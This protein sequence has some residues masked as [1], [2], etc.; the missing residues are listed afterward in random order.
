MRT[1]SGALLLTATTTCALVTPTNAARPAAGSVTSERLKVPS[2]PS[3]VR[4]LA[5]EP[6]VDPFL[7]QL[8][9]Q[10]PIELPGGFGGLAPAVALVY[11]GA[12]GNGPLGIGW[13]LAETTISR[14]T[15]LGVPRFDDTDVLEISG[16]AS[17]RLVAIGNGE[18]RVEGM[19]QTVRVREVGGGFEVDDGS[20]VRYRLGVTTAGRRE[21]DATSTLAW[22]VE[23]Q[24]NLMGERIRYEYVKDRG[25]LYPSRIVWGPS[26]VYSATFTYEA[27]NDATTSYRE[28]FR[29][30]TRK[31]LAAIQVIA[32]GVEQRAYQLAYD[33]TFPVARLAGVTA[34][35]RAG[36]GAW[37]ALTFTYG[38]NATPAITPITGIGNWRLNSG[39]TT[40]VDLDGDGAAEL[41]QLASGSHSYLTNQNGSF[42]GLQPLTGNAQAIAA[43]QLQDVDGDG[44]VELLQD[45]GNGWAVYKFTKTQWVSQA[46]SLPNGVWP[47]SVG[48]QLKQPQTTRFADLNG[49]GAVDAIQWDND[50]LKIRIATRTGIRAPYNVPKIAGGVVPSTQ[51]RFLDVNGDGLDDYVVT[52][53]SRLDVY[54]GHGDGTFEPALPIAYPFAGAISNPED[55][56]LADLDRD[57]LVDLM[58]LDLGTVRWFR[59]K[60]DGTFVATPVTL[61][62]PETLTSAVVVTVADINGNGSHDVVWSSTSGM[63]RMDMAGATTAGMLMRAQNG[64][65]LDTTFA[66][67][68]SHALAVEAAQA[69]NAWG[70]NIPIAMPVPVQKTTALGPGETPRLVSYGVRDAFWDAVE[71]QFVG[72]LSTT[73]TTAGATAAETSSVVTRYHAGTGTSRVLR[74]KTLTEQV[75]DGTGKRLAMSTHT[76]DTM[77]VAGLPNVPLLRRPILRASVSQHEDTMPIRKLEASF[78]YDALGRPT[79]KVD[80]GRVDLTGD[81][82]VTVTRYADDDT[83]WIRDRVCSEQIQN[84]AGD[85]TGE[86]QHLFGDDTQVLPLCAIGKGWARETRAW[87]AGEAR[88]VTKQQTRFDAHGNPIAIVSGGVERRLSYDPTGL[89]ES[90]ERVTLSPGRELVWRAMYD[91]VLGVI[92]ALTEPNGHTERVTYD[93]LGR[94]ASIAID[95]HAP[96]QVIEYDWT[97]PFPKTTTWTFDGPLA[98]VGPKPS[99]WTA[100]GRW[101]Q[102]VDVTNGKGEVRYSATRLAD[103][104]WII[105]NYSER[106]PNSRVV[107]AGRPVYATQLEQPA[108]PAGIVGDVLTYDPTGRLIRQRQPSGLTRSYSYTA[109]ER[110]VQEGN[111]APVRSVLDGMGRPI[112]TERSLPDGTREVVEASYDTTGRMTRMWLAGGA[113]QREFT[114]DTLGRL[115]QTSDP[116][117]GARTLV[118]DDADHLLS[119]TNAVGQTIHYR[120]DAVGRLAERDTGSVYRY[121]YDDARP[122]TTGSNLIGRL[123]WVEEPTGTVDASYDDFGRPILS[124]HRI[125][126]RQSEM[127]TAYASS[128][129][130]MRQSFD[131][132]F[133]Y[134]LR[135]D[136][137]GRLGA[138]GKF[139]QLLELDASGRSLRE[140]TYNGVETVFTRDPIGLATRVTVRDAGGAA[141]YDVQATRNAVN[142][143]SA[144]ADLDGAGLDHTATF[145]YD[146]F[147]RLTGASLGGFTFGYSYDVLHNM[148]SRTQSGPRPLGSFNGTYRYAETGRAPRQLT[149]IV[150]GGNVTHRFDYDAAGRQVAQDTMT[151]SF[152]ATDRVL[153]ITGAAGAIQHA[154]GATGD[155]VRTTTPDGGVTYFFGDGTTEH[156]GVREHDVMVGDMVVARVEM[157]S[158]GS[159]STAQ[160]GGF[161]SDAA[162][163]LAVLGL[164]AMLWLVARTRRGV[165]RLLPA[166]LA[167]LAS[168]LSCTSSLAI[169][170]T[171]Q[172]L[173]VASMTFMHRGFQ[174]GPAL[175]TDGDGSVVEERRYEP[176]GQPIDARI[177]TASSYVVGA[178]DIV[179][180]DLNILNKR[181]EATTGWSDHGA[182]WMAPETARWLSPDPPIEAPSAEFLFAPWTLHPYQYVN[183]DPVS[184]WDPDGNWPSWDDF[185]GAVGWGVSKLVSLHPLHAYNARFAGR[186]VQ[187]VKDP[188]SA[189]AVLKD[190]LVDTAKMASY[191]SPAGRGAVLLGAA[192][193]V[194]SGS[195]EEGALAGVTSYVSSKTPFGFCE[196]QLPLEDELGINSN[197]GV[198]INTYRYLHGNGGR[199]GTTETRH[200]NYYI[201]NMLLR[202]GWVITHGGGYF[203]E[204]YLPNPKGGREGGKFV[205][206]TAWHPKS[207]AILRVQTIDTHANWE[208]T[209]READ[210]LI[211]IY[212]R[213]G[214]NE[215]VIGVSKERV[216]SPGKKK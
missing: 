144:I 8:R 139:L 60:P 88:F 57:G 83:T 42:G 155:R 204:E 44:R 116:D 29:V 81:E 50:N 72:F 195:L 111:L 123:A 76:W 180:R 196:K 92:T 121:H 4:G 74:G 73:V 108:R 163:G 193:A 178:P 48:L 31:R 211:E 179:A 10:V 103:T 190:Q 14:S 201:A 28:G 35:G 98:D 69:G 20:G 124:R 131:D 46:A 165:R 129:L 141:V 184:F 122:G 9:Y 66:Y 104:Q 77:P 157:A 68:S 215:H 183:Q 164:T 115:V 17:G 79:R 189:G 65:G 156:A 171:Q 62:N 43:V 170:K 89:F 61:N 96:H 33:A 1:L 138:A 5:D 194:E 36:A 55:I 142:Q 38:A 206:I 56:E 84:L 145:A 120:Y 70:S 90:E 21:R 105:A 152:D 107:F 136:P 30:E 24:T 51:G 133:A 191:I 149:S 109:F 12:L 166:T 134:D 106:D 100:T 132:G 126:G 52:G 75:K 85:V 7:A 177:K 6:S 87:L 110:I 11:S 205:D 114:Y 130:V 173:G 40:L 26:D 82:M 13:S 175:F 101:R 151:L 63:W 118:Y 71:Q 27:R 150:D 158:S 174:A 154:Y 2:A 185:K 86:L 119:E 15:R 91:P 37:P 203:S 181:T 53:T 49:D 128:G 80:L 208:A 78:T 186:V 95:D 161:V 93:E 41:L 198:P 213:S 167:A 99:A 143:I 97:A 22:H 34:T 197:P 182:R 188:S 54:L 187:A 210:N 39:G 169:D 67:R 192:V 94:F 202:D 212:R 162:R 140:A 64:L 25:Q 153:R 18:Y 117:L 147:S 207:G 199:Y 113:V 112:L 58:K 125:D 19:G 146:A 209:K 127:T 200:H 102:T 23:E 172:S 159:G 32:F 160:G 137:A 168:L 59:G 3:S 45:T 176:F 135:Y 148:T 47:G 216:P 214:R 16:I